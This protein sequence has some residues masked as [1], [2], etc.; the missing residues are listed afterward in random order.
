M[1]IL[2][3]ASEMAP[4][5]SSGSLA[6]VLQALPAAL[7]ERGHQV[8]VVLPLH[9]SAREQTE[10]PLASTKVRFSVTVG[11]ASMECEIF[12]AKLKNGL[13]VI[14]VAR[15]EFFDR[16][17]IYG[18][19]GRD[20]QDNASR[21]IFFN[22]AVVEL[23]RR[24][25]PL[26]DLIHGHDWQC[27]LIPVFSKYRNLPFPQVLTVHDL[28]FQGNFWSQDFGL[29]NLPPDYFSPHGVEFY[30]SMNFLKSGIVFADR[31]IFPSDLFISE[32][33]EPGHGCGME[34]LLKESADKLVGI[35]D[36]V[37]GDVWNPA[38]D[39][40]LVANFSRE[41][42]A[43]K[44][45]CKEALLAGCSLRPAPQGPVFGMVTRLLQERGFDILLPALDRILADDSRLI[46][47]GEGEAPYEAQLRT[48]ARKHA[49][50]LHYHQGTD[51]DLARR[52]FAGSDMLLAPARLEAGGIRVMQALRYG[53]VP[54]VRASG[55]LRQIVEDFQPSA[56]TGNGFVFFDF[57][58]E[59][60]VDSVRRAKEVFANKKTWGKL[61]GR[62]MEA[63]CSWEASASRYER[64]YRALLS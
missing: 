35:P 3:A 28:G 5:A 4:F 30:G 40:R 53:A 12:E 64:L 15:D 37:D 55:G 47:V 62:A 9:R 14:F 11:E 2:M 61:M 54:L 38:T 31:V 6:D 32:A 24:L 26:P 23:S 36:G 46:I 7:Q 17:G 1:N 21:F 25:D 44:A 59:A 39:S 41:E 50:K 20:Y 34:T 13:Q 56:G 10:I 51:A 57:T 49:G 16:T 43:G 60:L 18:T 22:K 58:S 42:P 33:Q 45:D 52:V 48:A 29:T 8:S 63:D 19:N 27:G